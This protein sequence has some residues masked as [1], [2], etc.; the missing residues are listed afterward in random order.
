MKAGTGGQKGYV[1]GFVLECRREA[2]SHP[3]QGAGTLF[4]IFD[5]RKLSRW[6]YLLEGAGRLWRVMWTGPVVPALVVVK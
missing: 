1:I 6:P 3:R 5:S 2:I 4:L